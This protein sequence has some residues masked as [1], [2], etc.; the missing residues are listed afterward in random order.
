[1]RCCDRRISREPVGGKRQKA[2][3][4]LDCFECAFLLPENNLEWPMNR[5]LGLVCAH[6]IY[7]WDLGLDQ[8]PI[9][10][11]IQSA[12]KSL[13]TQSDRPR[14]SRRLPLSLLLYFFSITRYFFHSYYFIFSATPASTSIERIFFTL[15]KLPC[16]NTHGEN[17]LGK[18]SIII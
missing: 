16:A 5:G 13:T 11:N 9:V 3:P 14:I 7:S 4:P 17:F 1:M 15:R 2:P 12:Y 10:C 18:F 8:S 6:Q